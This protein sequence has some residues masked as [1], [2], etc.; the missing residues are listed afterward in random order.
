V[1]QAAQDLYILASTNSPMR[2]LLLSIA[3]QLTLSEPPKLTKEEAAAA[4][5]RELEKAAKDKISGAT[6]ALP[7]AVLEH[8]RGATAGNAPI[9]PPGHATT[10]SRLPLA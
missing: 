7:S 8:L 9:L 2:A 4:A 10:R 6:S 5:A 1:G 3:Q